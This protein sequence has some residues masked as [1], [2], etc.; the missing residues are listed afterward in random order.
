MADRVRHLGTAS[1]A[2]CAAAAGSCR[3]HVSSSTSSIRRYGSGGGIIGDGISADSISTELKHMG[4]G[5]VAPA[6]H[7]LCCSTELANQDPAYEHH[8]QSENYNRCLVCPHEQ[9]GQYEQEIAEWQ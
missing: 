9:G 8:A 2:V 4:G 3:F 7:V 6:T 5:C 1:G